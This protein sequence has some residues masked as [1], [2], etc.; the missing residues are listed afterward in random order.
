MP[1][2]VEAST[3]SRHRD[4]RPQGTARPPDD[5]RAY[6]SERMRERLDSSGSHIV[7]E[8]VTDLLP[9]TTF[10]VDG[11]TARLLSDAVL[12]GR[13]TA[14][15]RVG[16][17]TWAPDGPDAGEDVRFDGAALVG[18]GRR[19]PERRVRCLRSRR[20]PDPGAGLSG[21]AQVHAD[22]RL[23]L[24]FLEPDEARRLM[25]LV[26]TF[27]GPP[28]RCRRARARRASGDEERRADARRGGIGE[29]RSKLVAGSRI[30]PA[31]R[32]FPQRG[33]TSTGSPPTGPRARTS[34]A[35]RPVRRPR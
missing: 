27:G 5:A 20:L 21:V 25:G 1:C 16:A 28:P 19:L 9:N 24:P 3:R 11:A 13:I 8:S 4:R 34:R 10:Q 30:T 31:V 23:V 18:D 14:V 15:E 12:R 22:G 6:V 26:V 17:R 2:R 33:R 7:Y 32:S 29:R 35:Q